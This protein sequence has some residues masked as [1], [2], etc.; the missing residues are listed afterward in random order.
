MIAVYAR[1]Q[2]G[3]RRVSPSLYRLLLTAHIIASV[4]WLGVVFAKLVL[5]LA[6]IATRAPGVSDA[7]YVSMNVL[8]GAFPPLAISTIVTGVLL[9]LGTKW[10]LLQHY[11]VATKLALTVGV[12]ATAVQLGDRLA[13]QSIAAPAGPTADAVTILGSASAPTLLVSLSVAHLLMLGAATI[14]SVYKPW[15]KTWFA[16]RKT[17]QQSTSEVKNAVPILAG[18]EDDPT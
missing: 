8:N 15:G 18:A 12:I 1:N 10:G 5:G 11:W 13:R 6:A 2:Q 9:S 14:I 16:R 3:E 4:G 17:V 7:L